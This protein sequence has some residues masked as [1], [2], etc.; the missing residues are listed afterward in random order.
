LWAC[1]TEGLTAYNA[2]ATR[3]VTAFEKKWIEG[4]GPDPDD[5]LAG[6][7]DFQSLA[8]LGTG[9]DVVRRMNWVPFGPRLMVMMALSAV[10][11]LAPLLLFQYPLA[12]LVRRLLGMVLGQ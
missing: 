8:D 7:D 11:P 1:R 2:L 10:V 3:Y 5:P 4:E 12:E 6:T 9:V